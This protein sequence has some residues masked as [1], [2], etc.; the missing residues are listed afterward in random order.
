MLRY[1]LVE[2]NIDWLRLNFTSPVIHI[3]ILL[4]MFPKFKKPVQIGIFTKL[5]PLIEM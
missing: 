2:K 1:M 5:E 4:L 3:L